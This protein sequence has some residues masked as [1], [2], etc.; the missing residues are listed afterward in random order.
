MCRGPSTSGGLADQ[1]GNLYAEEE[2]Q[3]H[4]VKD[5]TPSQE[6]E[7]EAAHR[8]ENALGGRGLLMNM[9]DTGALQRI[10]MGDVADRCMEFVKGNDAETVWKWSVQNRE[11]LKEFWAE[12]P[13]DALEVKKVIEAKTA[14]MQAGVAA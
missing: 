14:N 4:T 2:M 11:A 3:A 7:Q 1:F 12:T 6:I 9:D 10:P 8:R 5:I 13:N